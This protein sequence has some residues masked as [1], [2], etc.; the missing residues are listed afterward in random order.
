MHS[1]SD[2]VLWAA[3]A[4]TAFVAARW[5][6][7]SKIEFAVVISERRARRPFVCAFAA[8]GINRVEVMPTRIFMAGPVQLKTG[9]AAAHW[10]SSFRLYQRAACRK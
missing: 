4:C 7:D 10:R 3:G 8:H 5:S 6:R 1:I 9:C 2:L